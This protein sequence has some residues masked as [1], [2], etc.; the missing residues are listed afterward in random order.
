VVG[1]NPSV[2]EREKRIGSAKLVVI[3]GERLGMTNGLV[4]RNQ[5]I[6]GGNNE[7]EIVS[8]IRH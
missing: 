6:M 4:D 7:L 3:V 2:Y 8:S 5:L 1:Q